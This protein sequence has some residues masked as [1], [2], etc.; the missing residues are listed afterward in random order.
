M[1]ELIL[2]PYAVNQHWRLPPGTI[3]WETFLSEY[4]ETLA[5]QFEKSGK[6]V[7]GH[8]KALA[9]FSNHDYVQISVI[10]PTL[11]ATVKGKVPL[12]CTALTLSLNVIVYGL[13]YEQL[14]RITN[15]TAIQLAKKYNGEVQNEEI[16]HRPIS[17]Q[18]NHNNHLNKESKHE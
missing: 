14:A 16:Q 2:E 4:L 8:I 9:L 6:C 7:V 11:P 12:D 1:A 18:H 17:G 13:A 5:Q 3:R 15:E 10:S